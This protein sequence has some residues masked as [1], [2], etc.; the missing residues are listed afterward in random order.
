MPL[1]GLRMLEEAPVATADN[2]PR[3]G[4]NHFTRDCF[5]NQGYDGIAELP[6]GLGVRDDDRQRVI[7]THEAGRLPRRQSSRVVPAALGNEN[8]RS[9][10]VVPCTQRARPTL[11]VG[12]SK[13]EAVAFLPMRLGVAL[14]VIPKVVRQGVL[15]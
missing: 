5:C 1:L 4:L 15:V 2:L 12:Y 10:L 13:A 14:Q 11:W 6:V 8:L 9:V 3:D 7:E